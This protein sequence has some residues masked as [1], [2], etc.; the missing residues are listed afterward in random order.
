MASLRGS[1]SLWD[2]LSVATNDVSDWAYIGSGTA[3]T[4]FIENSGSNAAT[5]TVQ[6]SGDVS[7]SAGL[8]DIDS[9]LADGGLTWYDYQGVV[10][11]SVA[12][13]AKAAFDLTPFGPQIL[14]LKCAADGGGANTV[15]AF[16]V[17]NG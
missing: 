13:G 14:R 17:C 8:N 3:V 6:V 10:A 15:T 5:F 16:V 11:E 2:A 9:S 12:S 1:T 4:V 7:V